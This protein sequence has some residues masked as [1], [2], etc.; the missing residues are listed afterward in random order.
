[1]TLLNKL[2]D[3][4]YE[5]LDILIKFIPVAIFITIV[6]TLVNLKKRT[7]KDFMDVILEFSI[8]IGLSCVIGYLTFSYVGEKQAVVLTA[9]VAWSGSKI[10]ATIDE[11]IDKYIKKYKGNDNNNGNSN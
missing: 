6:K 4:I 8:S 7:E 9:I 10:T 11:F 3:I 5:Y 1:M 2:A